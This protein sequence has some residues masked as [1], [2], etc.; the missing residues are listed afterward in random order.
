MR[1]I[2]NLAAREVSLELSSLDLCFVAALSVRSRTAA[3]PSFSEGDL[4]DVFRDVCALVQPEASG[5]ARRAT[6]AVQRL[7]DQRLLSRVDGAGIVRSGAYALTRLAT[8]IV[9][10]YL[11]EEAL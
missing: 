1:L 6:A 3:V 11:E 9:D 8:A 10:F 5:V 4:G 2:Q 7:R